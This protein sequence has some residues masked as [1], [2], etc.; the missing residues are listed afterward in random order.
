MTRDELRRSLDAHG[1]HPDAYDLDKSQKDEVYSLEEDPAGW[2]VYYRE[3][4]LRRDERTF[5]SEDDASRFFLDAV[6]K[7]P[8]TRLPR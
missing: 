5:A 2:S 1:V 7:D 4:G 8:T 6:L 3:R